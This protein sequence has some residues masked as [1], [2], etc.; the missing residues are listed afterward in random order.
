TGD[1]DRSVT[2]AATPSGGSVFKRWE[3]NGSQVSTQNPYTFSLTATQSISAVF[4][5]QCTLTVSAGSGGS[6]SLTSGTLTG[7]C[8]RSVTVT[9]TPNGGVGFT[10]WEVN[11]TPVSTQNPYTFSLTATQTI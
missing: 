11:G 2:V 9:A 3:V 10:R 1:C 5:A 7:D 8:D 6:G 4:A